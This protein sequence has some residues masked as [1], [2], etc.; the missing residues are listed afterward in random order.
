MKYHVLLDEKTKLK[1]SQYLFAVQLAKQ[2]YIDQGIDATRM[3]IVNDNG[4]C[5]PDFA[6]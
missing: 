3:Q 2:A 1:S 6:N 5:F 4:D